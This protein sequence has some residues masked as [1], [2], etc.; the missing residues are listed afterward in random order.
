MHICFFRNLLFK[1]TENSDLVFHIVILKVHIFVTTCYQRMQSSA[2]NSGLG[3]WEHPEA[4]CSPSRNSLEYMTTKMLLQRTK[5]MKVTWWPDPTQ[6]NRLQSL[7]QQFVQ[8]CLDHPLYSPH[9]TLNAVT[10]TSITVQIPKCYGCPGNCFTVV[11]L[12][13]LRIPCWRHYFTYNTLQQIHEPV[14][15]LC[16]KAD[17]CSLFPWDMLFW[18]NSCWKTNIHYVF[19]FV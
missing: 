18:A 1:I 13:N 8:E 16:G 14:V 10:W 2:Q 5:K 17:L 12:A 11:S 15:W 7:L 9:L 4:V 3:E 19:L 6:P